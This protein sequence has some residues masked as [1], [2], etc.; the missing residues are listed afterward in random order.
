VS[1]GN[2]MPT[3]REEVLEMEAAAWEGDLNA[4]LKITG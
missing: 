4:M 3:T 2:D 1:H